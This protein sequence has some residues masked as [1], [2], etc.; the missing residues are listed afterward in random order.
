MS[1]ATFGTENFVLNL[2][3]KALAT[4]ATHY[5]ASLKELIDTSNREWMWNREIKYRIHEKS[6]DVYLCALD[7]NIPY[8]FEY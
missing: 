8:T 6:M 1:T 7:T 4:D 3:L 5:V 2:K